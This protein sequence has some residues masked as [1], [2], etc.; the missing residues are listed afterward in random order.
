MFSNA[1]LA[2]SKRLLKTCEK[3]G[4]KIA[5]AESCTGG[6]IA[7]LLTEIPGSSTVFE[8][9]FVTYANT[10]KESLL[11]VSETALKRH[12]AVSP[13]VAKTMAE[14]ALR[15]G[16]ADLGIAV[17]GIA[18]PGGGS[19]AKPLGLVYIAVALRKQK[20][21]V[22]ECHFKGTRNFIRLAAVAASLKL[23]MA[24]LPHSS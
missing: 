14:G 23:A 2:Q 1:L 22:E 11:G 13:Q 18:G 7:A 6:L 12:G 24:R 3:H 19:Y 10:A 8:R 15:Y 4:I 20:T 17:T 16:E 5:T 9:G 21:L